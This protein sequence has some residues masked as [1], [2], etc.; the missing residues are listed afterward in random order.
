MAGC[1]VITV[2]ILFRSF[3]GFSMNIVSG[4][5]IKGLLGLTLVLPSASFAGGWWSKDQWFGD[6][7]QRGWFENWGRGRHHIDMNADAEMY[8]DMEMDYRSRAN[9]KYRGRPVIQQRYYQD[10]PGYYRSIPRDD[11][12]PYARQYYP[13]YYPY[14]R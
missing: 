5:V 14:R 6:G 4:A 10:Y 13:G 1:S 2:L 7:R 8:M 12:Y 11:Y 3:G 9:S